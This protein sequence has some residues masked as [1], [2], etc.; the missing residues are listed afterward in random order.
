LD[1]FLGDWEMARRHG[2]GYFVNSMK[3]I[4]R[5]KETGGDGR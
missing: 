4:F 2:E 1:D 3:I 5:D